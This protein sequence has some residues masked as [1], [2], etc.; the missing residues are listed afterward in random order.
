M[1]DESD[2][3]DP[4]AG[5]VVCL[6]GAGAGGWEWLIWRRVLAANGW[7]VQTPDLMPAPAGLEATTWADYRAQAERACASP[8][9]VRTSLDGTVVVGASLGGLL[10]L[11]VAATRP[12]RALVLVNPLPPAPFA[13]DLPRRDWPARMPWG[14]ARS[15]AGTRAALPDADDAAC[16]YALR[17]WRDESGQVLAQACAGIALAAPRCPVLVFASARDDD[18]PEATSRALAGAI[19]ADFIRIPDASHA[20]PLLGRDAA[21]VA[22]QAADWL[23]GLPSAPSS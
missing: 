17:R 20:G 14:R 11:A 4:G 12:L 16:L 3:T 15:L 7:R 1:H 2:A 19:A 6:H 21:A 13:A 8:A 18:V 10:A 5:D 22:Q 9:P 23:A